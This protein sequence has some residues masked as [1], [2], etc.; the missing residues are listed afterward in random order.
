M[1]IISSNNSINLAR[2]F[3]LHLPGSTLVESTISSF[4]SGEVEVLL[5]HPVHYEVV[6]VASLLTHKDL[7]EAITIIDAA[8]RAGGKKITLIAPYIFYSRQD[9]AK[10][11]SSFGMEVIA[12]IINSTGISKLITVDI[13]NKKSLKL[14]KCDVVN[15]SVS[16]IIRY[17]DSF[18][19]N[20]YIIVAPDEGSI[21]R[22]DGLEK[23]LIAM[24]KIRNNGEISVKLLSNVL[25]KNANY[26]IVDDIFDSGITLAA[27]V[28]KLQDLG[29]KNI[30]AYITHFLGKFA[31]D[32]IALYTTDTVQ[33]S[34]MPKVNKIFSV[35]K[36]LSKRFRIKV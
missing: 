6:V 24:S 13:H 9:D 23:N 11:F 29:V 1:H 2:D 36:L 8:K 18:L 16:E 31:P 10:P 5:S 3:S 19:P 27:A 20:G 25:D 33:F 32:N 26:L 28:E 17:Y 14:F 7:I 34:N 30:S 22:L 4:S 15:I 12:N 21:K 35:G